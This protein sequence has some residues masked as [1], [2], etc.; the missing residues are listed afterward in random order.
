MTSVSSFQAVAARHSREWPA[1][2]L[3]L[4]A[5]GM[6]DVSAGGNASGQAADLRLE[7]KAR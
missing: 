5:D 7:Q 4:A 6:L 3:P 1:E 2:F